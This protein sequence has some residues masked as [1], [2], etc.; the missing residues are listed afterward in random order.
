VLNPPG[1]NDTSQSFRRNDVAPQ[2]DGKIVVA[3]TSSVRIDAPSSD[4]LVARFNTNGTLD[5][6][7]AGGSGYVRLDVD[8]ATSVTSETAEAVVIQ[9][10][11]RI[12]VAGS[13]Y[14]SR[15][16]SNVLVVRLNP[17]GTPDASFGGTGFKLGTPPA[18]P[19]YH[20]FQGTAVALLS[21]GRI[22]V[23]GSDDW[24]PTDNTEPHPLLMRFNP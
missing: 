20:S 13:E 11:G 17:N 15:G 2:S 18:G 8:G 10:D 1:F 19:D 7:I 12:V 16:P 24:D 4:M 21:D 22:I 5:T 6:S 3:S 9:P 23:A 14:S